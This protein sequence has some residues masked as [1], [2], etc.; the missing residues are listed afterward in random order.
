MP[1]VCPVLSNYTLAPC[2]TRLEWVALVPDTGIHVNQSARN[3][4]LLRVAAHE[5]TPSVF[6]MIYTSLQGHTAREAHTAHT[7]VVR[8]AMLSHETTYECC[9]ASLCPND[10][11]CNARMLHFSCDLCHHPTN[12][13]TSKPYP[14]LL[15][16]LQQQFL[17]GLA[18]VI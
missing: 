14:A 5:G 12:P 15:S 4:R 16:S 18:L 9:V 6:F 3:M 1:T 7:A 11:S 2:H 17:A 8:L 13:N 10:M